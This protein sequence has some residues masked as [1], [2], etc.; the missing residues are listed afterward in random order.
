[1][2]SVSQS[3]FQL[4]QEE[5]RRRESE[6][7]A[8]TEPARDLEDSASVSVSAFEAAREQRLRERA[9][10]NLS[11]PPLQPPE[12]AARARRDAGVLGVELPSD[13]LTRQEAEFRRAQSALR[14]S[15]RPTASRS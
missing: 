14:S 6:T 7:A 15:P 12:M 2:T 10:T 13:D 1:M 3:A 9:E 8:V 4:A 5:R 11:T